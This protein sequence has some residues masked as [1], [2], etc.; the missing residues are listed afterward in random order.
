MPRPV[1]DPDSPG[2]IVV[3]AG[4]QIEVPPLKPADRKRYQ[5]CNRYIDAVK[6]K[7]AS[8]LPCPLWI[9][10][11]PL[12]KSRSQPLSSDGAALLK[13]ESF[14]TF[15]THRGLNIED[16]FEV[17]MLFL[18]DTL[19]YAMCLEWTKLGVANLDVNRTYLLADAFMQ[20]QRRGENAIHDGICAFCGEL[21]H[22]NLWAADGNK[23]AGPPMDHN[24]ELA[25]GDIDPATIQPPFL[26]RY[27][28]AKLAQELPE[29]FAHDS[30]TNVLSLKD[31]CC[32]PW[33]RPMEGKHAPRGKKTSKDSWL[34][35]QSC[36]KSRL[37][38]KD[39]V[40]VTFRDRR[41]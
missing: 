8:D 13:A 5:V 15:A 16:A 35:C 22:G 24:Q 3:P 33:L 10:R 26:L 30:G 20:G 32:M 29:I 4:A 19:W 6:T 28:P 7:A 14:E 34:Y 9:R 31:P 36:Y 2:V 27:S 1:A 38:K 25:T 11:R 40:V 41:R 18:W 23:I 17:L 12:G 39:D 21:L 37:Q